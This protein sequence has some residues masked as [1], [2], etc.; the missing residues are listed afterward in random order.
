MPWISDR[1]RENFAAPLELQAEQSNPS[2][3]A[4]L[5]APAG[6]LALR[7]SEFATKQLRCAFVHACLL[8][9]PAHLL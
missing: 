6:S 3:V 1:S 9:P 8:F 5:S 2:D 7:T 4:L